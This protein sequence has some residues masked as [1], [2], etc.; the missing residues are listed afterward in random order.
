MEQPPETPDTASHLNVWSALFLQ[1]QTSMKAMACANVSGLSMGTLPHHVAGRD[2]RTDTFERGTQGT[3]QTGFTGGFRS[4]FDRTLERPL[5]ATNVYTITPPAIV[6]RAIRAYPN[7]GTRKRASHC[8][9]HLEF[10]R[11]SVFR[12]LKNCSTS[13]KLPP[14]SLKNK[15]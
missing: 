9:I 6:A 12:L 14:I 5:V 13:Q 10:P 4:A 15:G 1:L 7:S 2:R 8:E 3:L 11:R